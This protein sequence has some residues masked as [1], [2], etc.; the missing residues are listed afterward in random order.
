V[1]PVLPAEHGVYYLSYSTLKPDAKHIRSIRTNKPNT[2][3]AQHI[4]GTQYAY[5]PVA[6][7]MNILHTERKTQ[8]MNT[9]E[10]FH[11]YHISSKNIQLND[12]YT[13][14]HNPIQLSP[15]E[16]YRVVRC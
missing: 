7:T 3:Y 5:G 4:P 10:R 13:D 15:L 14:T 12:M 11:I 16:T 2:K 6:N 1:D 8:L 9:W